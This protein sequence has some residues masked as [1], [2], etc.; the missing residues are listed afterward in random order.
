M[1][2][3]N[4]NSDLMDVPTVTGGLFTEHVAFSSARGQHFFEQA[5]Y[6]TAFFALAQNFEPQIHSTFCAIASSVVALNTLLNK[7]KYCQHS[8]LKNVKGAI[9]PLEEILGIVPGVEPGLSLSEL[10]E[11]FKALSFSCE[12]TLADNE[13]TEDLLR[14]SFRENLDSL[15]SV[16]IVNFDY[17]HILDSKGGHFSPVAAYDEG[18]DRVLV[19]DVARHKNGWFWIEIKKLLKA[20]NT[21]DEGTLRGFL[22]V[23]A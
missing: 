19:L 16:I 15:G 7:K 8:L 1:D 11:L 9:K 10:K 4:F 2:V 13:L 18:S 23:S 22:R 14:N 5:K 6:K 20:M 3:F 21:L 17:G 12:R